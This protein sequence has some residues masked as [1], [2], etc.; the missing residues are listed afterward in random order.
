MRM[1]GTIAPLHN[2]PLPWAEPLHLSSQRD[3]TL[4]CDSIDESNDIS[5]AE[6]RTFRRS[7]GKRS[8]DHHSRGPL[9]CVM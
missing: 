4:H 8:R 2:H 5:G 6:P 7:T 3:G 1:P 9:P